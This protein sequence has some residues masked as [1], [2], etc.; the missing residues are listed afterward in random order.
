MDA[1]RGGGRV[2]DWS[3]SSRRGDREEACVAPAPDALMVHVGHGD[4]GW[5]VGDNTVHVRE[6]HFS[7]EGCVRQV[8]L[9]YGIH[10]GS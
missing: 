6:G 4:L 5:V 1:S 9:G 8:C 7:D 3:G 10:M 2:E